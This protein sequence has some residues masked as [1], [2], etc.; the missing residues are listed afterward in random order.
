[1]INST[2]GIRLQDV[3]TFF[4][5][6]AANPGSVDIL[7]NISFTLLIV[8]STSNVRIVIYQPTKS[9]RLLN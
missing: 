6:I 8:T 5:N 2:S 9:H 1:M 3:N 7:Y 4:T